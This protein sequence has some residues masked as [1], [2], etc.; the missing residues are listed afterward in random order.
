MRRVDI[1]PSLEKKLIAMVARLIN[2]SNLAEAYEFETTDQDD[3]VLVHPI[4][5]TDF[6]LIAAEVM[7]GLDAPK[8]QSV[9]EFQNAIG[10]IISIEV[11][12]QNTLFAFRRRPEAWNLR[13]LA[14]WVNAIFKNATLV[15]VD[16]GVVLRLDQH[17]DFIGFREQLFVLNKKNFEYG[18]NF[19][20]GMERTRDRVINEFQSR[21]LFTD[22]RPLRDKV[23]SNLHYLR[24]LTALEKSGYYRDPNFMAELERASKAEGWALEFVDGK[25]VMTAESLDLIITLLCNNRVQSMVNRER[26]DIEG[27]KKP[28]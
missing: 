4:S 7:R 2:Q 10:T 12:K 5:Q 22:V 13:K 24:K 27:V 26:F 15:D 25:I 28:I 23:A 3:R 9:E 8:V 21:N 6:P 1:E 17:I 18:L 11:G 16:A 14:G 19:R 20:E